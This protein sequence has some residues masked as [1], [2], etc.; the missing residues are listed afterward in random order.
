[1]KRIGDAGGGQRTEPEAGRGQAA[2][3]V[4]AATRDA[5][6]ANHAVKG[7]RA[8]DHSPSLSFPQPP[9]SS[10]RSRSSGKV[11]AR[12]RPARPRRS[13]SDKALVISM[14]DGNSRPLMHRNIEP[15]MRIV[16]FGGGKH[17]TGCRG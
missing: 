10:H 4:K 2:E 14:R 9:R 5:L 12:S 1:F 13:R 7:F 3:L 6:P 17:L 11:T 8:R 16:V 15:A